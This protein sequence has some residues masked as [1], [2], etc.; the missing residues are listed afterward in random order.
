MKIGIINF[1][2][3][4]YPNGSYLQES[5][6]ALAT[7]D[8]ITDLYMMASCHP[9]KDFSSPD[10]V[11][12]IW[13]PYLDIPVIGSILLNL[14]IIAWGCSSEF[15]KVDLINVIS[16]RPVIGARVLGLILKRPVV[17]TVEIINVG[18]GTLVDLF[19]RWY[20]RAVFSLPFSAI[21]CWSKYYWL[22]YLEKWGLNP[23]KVTFISCGIS[24]DIYQ[25]KSSGSSIRS[26][27]PDESLVI[28]FAK[29][30]YDY[31]F[32]M[33]ALLLRAVAL[34]GD[35]KDIR[36]IFGSG[37]LQH[38]LQ[39]LI[40]TLNLQSRAEIMPWVPF[41]E[42]PT[43]I[44]ASDIIVL[45]FTYPPTSSRSLLESLAMGKA[46]ITSPMGEV[47]YILKD[48][49]DALIVEPT[50]EAIANAILKLADQP[51]LRERLG[52]NALELVRSQFSSQEIAK[53]TADVYRQ[54]LC[55]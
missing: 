9:N 12:L 26:R 6:N 20:Q 41:T 23:S 39:S 35:N 19:S 32:R 29:P 50:E 16:A 46:V 43:Y 10:K 27:F 7:E 11:H 17:C 13:L 5:V 24:L 51:A 4:L 47:P 53:R 28:V 54:I 8:D 44:A 25:Q 3:P 36:L 31:N 33:A 14:A 15:R 38:E 21:I 52:T 34:I 2:Y 45:P 37:E 30:M 18:S 40:E 22:N 1:R 42:I 49:V 55:H 48:G